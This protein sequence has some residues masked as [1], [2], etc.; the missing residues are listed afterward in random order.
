GYKKQVSIELDTLGKSTCY[1]R[2]RDNGKLELKHGKQYNRYRRQSRPSIISQ[3]TLHHKKAS[4]MP[5]DPAY[6]IPKRQAKA[7]YHPN[8]SDQPHTNKALQHCRN[9]ILLSHH[10]TI[11]KR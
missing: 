10:T 8:H 6:I 5:N 9:N 2:W 1:Q 7:H 4:R 11:K 3:H